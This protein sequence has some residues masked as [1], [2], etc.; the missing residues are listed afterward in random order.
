MFFIKYNGG[1][2]MGLFGHGYRNSYYDSYGYE[3]YDYNRFGRYR[4]GTSC[5]GY[6][7]RDLGYGSH[8]Y[9]PNRRHNN[10]LS[11]LIPLAL[12]AVCKMKKFGP[13]YNPYY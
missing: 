2:K 1:D 13:Y 10:N 12:L 4:Y 11:L 3:G 7:P 6:P 8:G 5:Y 9:Y